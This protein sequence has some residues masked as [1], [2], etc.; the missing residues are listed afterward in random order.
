MEGSALAAR[1]S[2]IHLI[3]RLKATLYLAALWAFCSL[4]AAEEKSGLTEEQRFHI[5]LEALSRLPGAE[6]NAAVQVPLEKILTRSRGTP[7]FVQLVKH[8]HL[9]NQNVGLLEIAQKFPASES[10]VEAMSMM[11]T[12]GG[13]S[14]LR[15]SLEGSNAVTVV[16]ALG[17][18]GS[19]ESVPLLMPLVIDSE[20]DLALRKKTVQ[21]AARTLEGAQ[22]LID[23]A[24][25]GKLS[26]DLKLT[27]TTELNKVRW[28]KVKVEAAKVLPPLQGHDSV[29]LP[30][31]DELMRQRGEASK[32]EKIFYRPETTCSVCHKIKNNGGEIGPALTEIGDKLG[33]DALFESILEPSAGISFGYEAFQIDLKSGDEAYGMI[34][35]ETDEELVMK[36]LKGIVTHHKKSDVVKRQQM[37]TSIMPAGLQQT[38]SPQ[39]LV[40]LVEFLSTLRKEK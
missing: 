37:K 24:T 38:M 16:E 20:R 29:P 40:D 27:A 28:E 14:L 18:T 13:Q 21:A 19:K 25:E 32:G 30:G 23:L 10:G 36:D 12:N 39:D 22:G 35:S 6:S 9:T 26:A 8:L 34:T 11:L 33:K 1:R 5:A 7:Q 4:A 2:S 3:M 15:K 31:L 17:N